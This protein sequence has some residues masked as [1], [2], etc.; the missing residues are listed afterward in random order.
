MTNNLKWTNCQLLKK[1]NIYR[2]ESNRLGL[3]SGD[4]WVLPP[5]TKYAP[6]IEYHE[7]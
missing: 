5:P 2:I 3:G 6:E 1:T 4:P 7:S